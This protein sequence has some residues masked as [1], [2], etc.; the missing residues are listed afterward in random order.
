MKLKSLILIL[1]AAAGTLSSAAQHNYMQRSPEP[2]TAMADVRKD[3]RRGSAAKAKN[4]ILQSR[5]LPVVTAPGTMPAQKASATADISLSGV[6]ISSTSWN[7]TPAV[8]LYS[9]DAAS[10]QSS[11]L[12]P[13]EQVSGSG[14]VAGTL[15]GEMLYLCYCEDFYG[16][17]SVLKTVSLNTITGEVKE[18]EF[19]NPTYDEVSVNMTYDA[20]SKKIY[21]INYDGSYDY[22][23]LC[24]FD[25]ATMSY[26]EIGA[27]EEHYYGICSDSRGHLYAIDDMGDVKELNPESGAVTGTVARTGIEPRYL[28]SCCWSPVDGLIYWAACN[29]RVASLITINPA[30][31]AV[32]T[33]TGFPHEE[34]F[35][36]LSCSD[37]AVDPAAAAAPTDVKISYTVAGGNE[38]VLSGT[39]PSLTVSGAALT[40]ELTL[41]VTVDNKEVYTGATAA[42]AVFSVPLTLENGLHRIEITVRNGAG[43]G[44]PAIMYTYTGLD[45]PAAPLG[46]DVSKNTPT[47]LLLSWTAPTAG[48]Q[49]G[50]FD[51]AAL[52]YNII[53]DGKVIAS[54]IKNTSYTLILPETFLTATYQV[55]VCYGGVPGAMTEGITVSTG[56]YMSLPYYNDFENVGDFDLLTVIDKNHDGN[57]WF[58]DVDYNTASYNYSR[59]M[60]GDDL[61]VMPVIHARAGHT[62][63]MNFFARSSSYSY[64]DRLEVACST[65]LEEDGFTQ[66]LFPGRVILNEGENLSVEYTA[67]VDTPLYFAFHCVSDKDMSRLFV[68][69]IEII[70]AGVPAHPAAPSDLKVTP[71][72]DG[73]LKVSLSFTAPTTT[74]AGEPVQ[75]LEAVAVYR[76]DVMIHS[77]ISP[78]PGMALTYTD[79]KAPFGFNTYA[80]AATVDGEGSNKAQERVFVGRYSLPFSVVPDAEEFTLFN[81]PGGDEDGW[82]FDPSE[83]ALKIITYGS[84][85]ADNYIFTPVVEFGT[86]NLVDLSFNYRAGLASYPERL[87]VTF[88]PDC[89]PAHH[90]LITTLE[91]NNEEYRKCLE[92]IEVP[93]AGS[94]YIGFHALSDARQM[95]M[96]V[97]DITLVNGSRVT[98]PAAV[99]DAVVTADPTCALIARVGFTMPVKSIKDEKLEA[100]LSATLY[101]QDGTVAQTA[102]GLQPGAAV[103]LTDNAAA[104][105]INTYTLTV[106]N[107]AGEGARATVS[108]WVG[109]DVP[110]NIPYLEIYPT[111]D[112]LR[113]ELIWEAP[114][115]SLHGGPVTADRITYKIYQLV[116][117]SLYL[118]QSTTET[119]AVVAPYDANA[120]NFCMFYVTAATD[121]GE[122]KAVNNGVVLGPPYEL[123]LEETASNCIITA[124][125]WIA[126]PLVNDVKWGLSEYIGSLDL[127]AADGGMFVCSAALPERRPGVGRMQL[128]K[129]TLRGLNAPVLTFSMYHYPVAGSDV[130]VYV[131]S[132]EQ[133]YT[134]LG[135]YTTGGSERGWQQYTIPLK[136]FTDAPWVAII[137]DGE[138]ENGSAYAIIDDISVMNRSEHDLAIRRVTGNP[139]VEAG[140]TA[141][142][143]LTVRNSGAQPE[144]FDVDLRVNGALIQTAAHDTPLLSGASVDI[145]LSFVAE[146][147]HMSAPLKMQVEV[148][149]RNCVDEI[150]ADNTADFEVN[151]IQPFLPV[152]TDLMA[153]ATQDGIALSWT[154]PSL[155]PEAFTDNFMS[156]ESFEYDS[157]GPYITEDRDMMVPCG[158]QGVTFPNMGTP[159][160]F[161]VWEPLA[162]GVDVDAQIWQPHSGTKCLVAW[163]ALS[164]IEE[165]YN[166]DWLISPLL[167]SMPG[168]TQPLSFY[169]RRPVGT[170]GPESYEVWYSDGSDCPDDF[171]LLA[172]E[173][174]TSQDWTERSY[175]LPAGARRFAIRYTSRNRFAMLLDDLTYIPA[176]ADAGLTLT[177]FNVHR[178]G[179][180]IADVSSVGEGLSHA[181]V[182]A[183]APAGNTVYHLTAV[184]NQGEGTRSNKAYAL[185]SVG[186]VSADAVMVSADHGHITV[187]A[188][189]GATVAIY[190][191][192]GAMLVSERTSAEVSR[193]AVAPAV[194]TVTVGGQVFKVSVR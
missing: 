16:T 161:Q 103:T 78:A 92:S 191:T 141:V 93:Q 124:Y 186:G 184:Y 40:G 183:A 152:V 132:D 23:R 20:S 52:S 90:K 94:Y 67:E 100:P 192:S 147:E 84:E 128:P 6:M 64:P 122:S 167:V 95:Y 86:A 74:G 28:Q 17:I 5:K 82:Y 107:A 1:T 30:T 33:A 150:P 185:S 4:T 113:A 8:G 154:A 158:I 56:M 175:Q 160:A 125:P 182:D 176:T 88:G 173:T 32:A 138:L 42:G 174:V 60:P 144:T 115:G 181:Y 13:L 34:E 110:E 194:Y 193:Y 26:T 41:C 83:N 25:A 121:A 38:A 156:Y 47:E 153:E 61:L 172:S 71:D 24:T 134:L 81:I 157:F 112:N 127:E 12:F 49:G 66:V 177:H 142:Y 36:A 131:T 69:D 155:K 45:T 123:P 129:L 70:D 165:P 43:E 48:A 146:P 89:N 35:V 57:T 37:P 72:A 101:R 9:V 98:A 109:V 148:T 106:S 65:V 130:K 62:Y 135:T 50:W 21:S 151:V 7:G 105:G 18:K 29:D 97:R 102:D 137:F 85:P 116:N 143:T 2:A 76:N 58:H 91:F 159:M 39:M 51:P 189:Q 133:D 15:A 46:F 119:E 178:N 120:Q 162:E 169:V 44:V 139:S 3:V 79:T 99:E 59:T 63:R 31:G 104:H 190:A 117:N 54:D 27:L 166:D 145:P 179:E 164:S 140:S 171:T 96:Q 136:D 163:T 22:Y 87:A 170:Y 111:A 108:G 11:L 188:P 73:A 114:E 55:Q 80:V 168:S 118:I 68:D 10:G 180:R 187:S 126:G 14:S 149:P 53:S 75:Q 19:S 77:F